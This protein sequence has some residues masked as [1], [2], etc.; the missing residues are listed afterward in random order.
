[1]TNQIT[2]QTLS[3]HGSELVTLKVEDVVYTA[4]RPIVEG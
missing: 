2:T 1:M 3:F 4:V